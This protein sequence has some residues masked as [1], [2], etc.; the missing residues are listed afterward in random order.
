[1]NHDGEKSRRVLKTAEP[2]PRLTHLEARRIFE[3]IDGSDVRDLRDRALIALLYYNHVRL[4]SALLMK[5]DDVFWQNEPPYLRV[6]VTKG[7]DREHQIILPCFP[8]AYAALIDYVEKA[9]FPSELRG[10]LF[11]TVD[12]RTG[13]VTG[14]SLSARMAHFSINQLAR[15]A[16]IEREISLYE[17]LAAGTQLLRA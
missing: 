4:G 12:Q 3:S 7:G 14:E 11:R 1:M 13:N 2:K 10:P 5:P 15:R 9:L 8:E 17:F 16:G 6:L